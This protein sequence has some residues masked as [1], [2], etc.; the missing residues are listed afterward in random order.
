LGASISIPAEKYKDLEQ[1]GFLQTSRKQKET[2][3][4]YLL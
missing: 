3:E 1:K 4:H 2:E